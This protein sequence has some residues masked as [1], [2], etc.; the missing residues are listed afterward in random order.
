MTHMMNTRAA[1][2]GAR[3]G[4]RDG[5][6][7]LGRG[8]D[9]TGQRQHVLLLLARLRS[10]LRCRPSA[11]HGTDLRDHRH[12]CWRRQRG[13][14]RAPDCRSPALGRAGVGA[15]HWRGRGRACGQRECQGRPRLRG[16]RPGARH[17]CRRGGHRARR[18]LHTRRPEHAP[19]GQRPVLRRVCGPHRGRAQGGSW[20]ARRHHERRIE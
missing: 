14:D 3:P 15:G 8:R 7:A 13:A 18:G 6:G 20:R 12:S 4:L 5:D 10:R 1:H 17:C 9:P 19:E 16:V 2:H 11:L